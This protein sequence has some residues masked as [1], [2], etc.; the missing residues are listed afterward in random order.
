[1]P[2]AWR[3]LYLAVVIHQLLVRRNKPPNALMVARWIS[4]LAA[5]S[6]DTPPLGDQSRSHTP[7]I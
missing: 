3:D 4:L 1:M 2:L 6:G 5:A 7:S